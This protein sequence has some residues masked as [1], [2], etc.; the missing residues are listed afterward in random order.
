MV[1]VKNRS[2]IP[3]ED[4]FL[5]WERLW[6]SFQFSTGSS[7]NSSEC[8]S[9]WTG[10]DLD[11]CSSCSSTPK[12][13]SKANLPFNNL[14]VGSIYT[15]QNLKEIPFTGFG[16]QTNATVSPQTEMHDK[17]FRNLEIEQ[18]RLFPLWKPDYCSF[19][20]ASIFLNG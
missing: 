12:I 8:F 1:T 4:L 7:L 6:C 2:V 19:K 18:K 9:F 13:K 5:I 14:Q 15:S 20:G 3:A 16:R 11:F 10:D 17:Y